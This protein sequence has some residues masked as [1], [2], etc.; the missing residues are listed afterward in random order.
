MNKIVKNH[1]ELK[2]EIIKIKTKDASG[3]D[4]IE[5]IKGTKLKSSSYGFN[6]EGQL[7]NTLEL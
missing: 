3:K 4:T 1:Q 2:P 7:V 5:E 6:S